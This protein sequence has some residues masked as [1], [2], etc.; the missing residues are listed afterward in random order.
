MGWGVG[1]RAVFASASFLYGSMARPGSRAVGSRPSLAS[2][3]AHLGSCPRAEGPFIAAR[4]AAA[5]SARA[6]ATGAAAAAAGG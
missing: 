6:T 3:E 4:A 1:G 2:A 5:A